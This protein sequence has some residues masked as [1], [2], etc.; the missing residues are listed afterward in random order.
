MRAAWIA[1]QILLAA[2]SA[3]A[4]VMLLGVGKAPGLEASSQ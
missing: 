2:T 4:G 3:S 1:A